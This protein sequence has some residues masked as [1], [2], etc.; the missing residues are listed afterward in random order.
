MKTANRIIILLFIT[1]T[2]CNQRENFNLGEKK[3]SKAFIVDFDA[4]SVYYRLNV[5]HENENYYQDEKL[6]LLYL[7]TREVYVD[8]INFGAF[9]NETSLS[10]AE[11]Y[12]KENGRNVYLVTK[13]SI[14][15][16]DE[17][18]EDVW[19]YKNKIDF[20]ENG[21]GLFTIKIFLEESCAE[22]KGNIQSRLH[23]NFKTIDYDDGYKLYTLN[24]IFENKNWQ[25]VS[26]ERV[27]TIPND[28]N[29]EEIGYCID[30]INNNCKKFGNKFNLTYEDV[31][32]LS[33]TECN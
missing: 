8:D 5:G 10:K 30:T 21:Y 13:I 16:T 23:I 20:N 3:N 17:T 19:D 2:S 4:D 11:N 6:N 12:S 18:Y 7:V 22:Y 14:K 15:K 27:C 32:K 33:N 1:L 24:Y 28:I 9:N 31:F 29:R 25:L 26:R